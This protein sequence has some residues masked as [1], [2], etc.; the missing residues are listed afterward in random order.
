M[1]IQVDIKGD[2]AEVTPM[3][4]LTASTAEE[5]R[6][7]LAA[8]HDQKINRILLNLWGINFIDSTGLNLCIETHKRILNQNGCIVFFSP[9]EAVGKVFRMTGAFQKL[10]MVDSRELGIERLHASGK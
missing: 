7:Q 9:S 8:L 10:V 5:L 6:G 2:L 4:D 1:V 3:G